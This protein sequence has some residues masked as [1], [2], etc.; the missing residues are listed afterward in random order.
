[1]A[2]KTV[3]RPTS[4]KTPAK[5]APVKKTP[6]KKAPAKRKS[7]VSGLAGLS[8]MYGEMERQKKE[9]AKRYGP[10]EFYI[11][12]SNDVDEMVSIIQVVDED[13]FPVTTH[14][15]RR[16]SSTGKEFYEQVPC[17]GSECYYCDARA[18]GNNSVSNPSLC[19]YVTIFDARLTSFSE[20]DPGEHWVK[21]LYRLTATRAVTIAQKHA[22]QANGMSGIFLKVS[23][24]GSGKSTSYDYEAYPADKIIECAEFVGGEILDAFEGYDPDAL[25]VTD[26]DG[27]PQDPEPF[28]YEELFAPH[29]FERASEVLGGAT[30]STEDDPEEPDEEDEEDAGSYEDGDFGEEDESA[31][32]VP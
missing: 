27:K 19:A 17:G 32:P 28:D 11:K 15:V 8:Q 7:A 26:P 31:W 3:R 14:S 18:N 10:P 23:R 12:H 29:D 30:N 20:D 6:A 1:M 24:V 4:K 16:L 25:W 13:V 22:V 21:K 2:D 9:T 5:K